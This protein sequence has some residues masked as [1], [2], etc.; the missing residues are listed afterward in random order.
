MWIASS[1]YE[2]QSQQQQRF[3]ALIAMSL[4]HFE[5]YAKKRRQLARTGTPSFLFSPTWT[6]S[7]ENS[8]NRIACCR[9]PI[10]I[11]LLYCLC[12][13]GLESQLSDFLRGVRRG[14]LGDLSVWQLQRINELHGKIISAEEKTTSELASLQES[15]AVQRFVVM[16]TEFWRSPTEASSDENVRCLESKGWPWWI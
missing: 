6:S 2:K 3:Q 12:G 11:R 7:F 14:N 13:S 8:H 1:I 16:S 15:L 10:Y 9:P 4:N 5:E